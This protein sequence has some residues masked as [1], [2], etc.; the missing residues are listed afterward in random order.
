MTV[1]AATV[2]SARR[3]YLERGITGYIYIARTI[4]IVTIDVTVEVTEEDVTAYQAEQRASSATDDTESEAGDPEF[5][6]FERKA[7]S[8]MDSMFRHL[9]K[10]A[11]HGWRRVD[12]AERASLS[13]SVSIGFISPIFK[14][15]FDLYIMFNASIPTLIAHYEREEARKKAAQ[16]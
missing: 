12:F 7:V 5:S 14:F 4:G 6:T 13:R 3:K 16:A 11:Y 9:S 10:K 2:P 15:G 1:C 8:A